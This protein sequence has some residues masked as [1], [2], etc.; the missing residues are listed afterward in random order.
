MVLHL[1]QSYLEKCNLLN[2]LFQQVAENFTDVKFVKIQATRC[3]E[4]FPDANLPCVIIYK[5]GKMLKNLPNF[6]KLN[7]THKMNLI[8][9]LRA[10]MKLEVIPYEEIDSEDV[11]F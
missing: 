6:D 9:I 7:F 1:Y 5:D 3:I 2:H 10:L 11:P 8:S 4:N